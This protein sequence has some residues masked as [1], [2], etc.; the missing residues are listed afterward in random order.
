[1][2]G[3]SILIWAWGCFCL[4]VC[5][6]GDLKRLEVMDERVVDDVGRKEAV[7]TTRL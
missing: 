2:V 5:V 3:D 7:S 6:A 4:F 1:M